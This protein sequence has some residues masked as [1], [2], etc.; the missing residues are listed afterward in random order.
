MSGKILIILVTLSCMRFINIAAGA[1]DGHF[2]RESTEPPLPIA[3]G[4][5]TLTIDVDYTN[6]HTTAQLPMHLAKLKLGL[7]DMR[8]WISL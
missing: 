1:D 4:D 8:F 5:K 2:L 7:Q 6:D 3:G